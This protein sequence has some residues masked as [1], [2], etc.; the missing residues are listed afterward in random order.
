MGCSTPG[1]EFGFPLSI[2]KKQERDLLSGRDVPNVPD[3]DHFGRRWDP[4]S[5]DAANPN[6]MVR[7]L[8]E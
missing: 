3:R 7:E 6:P 5:R 8:G 1:L 2:M 4:G